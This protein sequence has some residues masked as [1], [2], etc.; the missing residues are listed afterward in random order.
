MSS[1]FATRFSTVIAPHGGNCQLQLQ[2]CCCARGHGRSSSSPTRCDRDILGAAGEGGSM[3]VETSRHV[4][5]GADPVRRRHPAPAPG[6]V[7]AVLGPLVTMLLGADPPIRVVFWDGS[8][9]GPAPTDAVGTL[10]VRSPDAVRRVLWCPNELGLGRAYVAGELD[11]EGDVVAIVEA[12]RDVAPR[13]LPLR[14]EGRA[15]RRPRRR[16]GCT[17]SDGRSRR[18]PRRPTCRGWRHS[19]RPRRRR[20]QPPLRRRQRLL[21]HGARPVDDVLVRPLRR[22]GRWTSPRRRRRSTT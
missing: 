20:H 1:P 2:V 10:I 5:A 9:V 8:A 12:L 15:A 6:S 14:V 22:A 3:T 18:R 17:S 13:H 16:R 19:L 7:A 21:P 4:D 11:V